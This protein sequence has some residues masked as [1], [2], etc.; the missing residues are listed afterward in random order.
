MVIKSIK[1]LFPIVIRQV[2]FFVRVHRAEKFLKQLRGDAKTIKQ[3]LLSYK[4]LKTFKIDFTLVSGAHSKTLSQTLVLLG[5]QHPRLLNS[6]LLPV[7]C[8]IMS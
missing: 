8:L 4:D 2:T 6:S 3:T 1:C 5:H 7:R